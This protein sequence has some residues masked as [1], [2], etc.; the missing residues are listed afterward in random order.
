MLYHQAINLDPDF[1][2]AYAGLGNAQREKHR[3][4]VPRETWYDSAIQVIKHAIELEPELA[5]AYIS[6]AQLYIEDN[7]WDK[8]ERI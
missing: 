7:Q 6:R 4:G 1:A 3:F 2:M 5:D 8:A